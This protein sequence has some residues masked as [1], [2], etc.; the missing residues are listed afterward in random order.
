MVICPPPPVTRH[1]L[2]ISEGPDAWAEVP[3]SAPVTSGP[4]GEDAADGAEALLGREAAL[5]AVALLG[6]EALLAG[7]APDARAWLSPITA[8]D[9]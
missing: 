9:T 4:D 7:E 6:A 2:R 8:G 3:A 1:S 5:G